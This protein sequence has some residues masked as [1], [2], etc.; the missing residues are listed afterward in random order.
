V[1]ARGGADALVFDEPL[2]RY[3][4]KQKFGSQ[5]NVLPILLEFQD[6][7]FGLPQGS[8]LRESVNRIL[9]RKIEEP[10]WR[11]VLQRYLGE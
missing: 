2:L 7:G 5:V 11:A 4:V 1:L 9:L 6:Y 8:A 3:V 10:A